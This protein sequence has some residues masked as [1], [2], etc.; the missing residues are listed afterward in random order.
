MRGLQPSL[1]QQALCLFLDLF[2]LCDRLEHLETHGHLVPPLPLQHGELPEIPEL[3]PTEG[4][5]VPGREAHHVEALPRVL[6]LGQDGEFLYVQPLHDSERDPISDVSVHQRDEGLPV[7]AGGEG[8]EEYFFLVPRDGLREHRALLH[9]FVFARFVVPGLRHQDRPHHLRA[10]PQQ[11][12]AVVEVVEHEEGQG[13]PFEV[14]DEDSVLHSP[15]YESLASKKFDINK[16]YF[17]SPD[18][19]VVVPFENNKAFKTLLETYPDTEAFLFCGADFRLEKVSSVLGFGTAK[20]KSNVRI[21][22]VDRKQK[23]IMQKTSNASSEEK[24]KFSLGGVF[25]A[26]QIQPL[27][28]QATGKAAEKFEEWFA[29]KMD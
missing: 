2:D 22:A 16:L 7:R 28:V 29:N 19:Y 26:S 14:A 9:P 4:G 13:F 1:L 18:G 8:V 23:V 15:A 12:E 21:V 24:I 20:V 11:G 3:A 6:P 10:R 5:A 17:T 27:C 25:D